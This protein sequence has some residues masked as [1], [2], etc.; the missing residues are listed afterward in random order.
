MPV[1]LAID[2]SEAT[3]SELELLIREARRRRR[4]RRIRLALISVPTF[5]SA[6]VITAVASGW[7]PALTG[8]APAGRASSGAS[9][10]RCPVSPARFVANSTFSATVIG[11]GRVRL[12]VG[13]IYQGAQRRVVVYHRGSHGWGGIEAIWVVRRG[14]PLP[15]VARGVAL[16]KRAAVEVQAADGGQTQGSGPLTLSGPTDASPVTAY[17][18]SVYAGSL[19]VRT[20][21]CYAVDVTGRGFS[22]RLVFDVVTRAMRS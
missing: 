21:G 22:E 11:D 7:L 6:A 10:A 18:G 8:D 2:K 9:T 19:W 13:N 15:L 17:P 14:A 20:G 5:G 12:G 4:R 3:E 1:V 16:G